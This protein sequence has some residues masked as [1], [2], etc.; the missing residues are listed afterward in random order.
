MADFDLSAL[1]GYHL[2]AMRSI[3]SLSVVVMI[4]VT[5][6]EL[7]TTGAPEHPGRQTDD[8]DTGDQLKIGLRRFNIPIEIR[9]QGCSRQEPD[10]KG[11]RDRGRETEQDRLGDRARMAMIKAAIIVLEWPGS[12]PCRTR[13]AARL[14]E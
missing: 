6:V 3:A 7:I 8:D 1:C 4:V 12:S 2:T 10:D 5:C 9:M 14:W 13:R 11:V